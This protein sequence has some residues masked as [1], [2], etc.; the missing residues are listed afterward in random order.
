MGGEV[1][2]DLRATR[3]V[4]VVTSGVRFLSRGCR[5]GRTSV[6][7]AIGEGVDRDA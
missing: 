6:G 2:M 3:E 7:V 4:V 5:A 1:N